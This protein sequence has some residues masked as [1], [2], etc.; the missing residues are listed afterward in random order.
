MRIHIEHIR[1]NGLTLQFEETP[2]VFPVLAELIEKNAYEFLAPINFA[3]GAI[4]G[5]S[6][7]ST[8]VGRSLV[9]TKS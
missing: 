8:P 4:F 1:D 3:M 7:N 5:T 9:K 2:D 6:K